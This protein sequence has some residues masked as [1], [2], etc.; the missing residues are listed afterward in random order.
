MDYPIEVI[1]GICFYSHSVVGAKSLFKT[2]TCFIMNGT[3]LIFMLI[4]EGII[5]FVTIYF[6]MKVLRS[7]K[8]FNQED[9]SKN[10]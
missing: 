9:E 1:A 10:D 4:S 7:K 5:A 8:G 2:K 3:A 6:F